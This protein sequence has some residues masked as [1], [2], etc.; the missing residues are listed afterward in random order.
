V[1]R[2]LARLAWRYTQLN[3]S[4]SWRFLL[5]SWVDIWLPKT[6]CDLRNFSYSGP[7]LELPLLSQLP[8]D[9]TMAVSRYVGARPNSMGNRPTHL[10][11]PV[12]RGLQSI[13]GWCFLPRIHIIALLSRTGLPLTFDAELSSKITPWKFHKNL[14]SHHLLSSCS[15]ETSTDTFPERLKPYWICFFI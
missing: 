14:F 9:L 11:D 8:F 4:E 12:W 2:R 6:S 5:S 10:S 3:E 1:S 15:P 13:E 7:G